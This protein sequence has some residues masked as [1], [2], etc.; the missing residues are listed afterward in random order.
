MFFW[1]RVYALSLY[2]NLNGF[3]W[4]FLWT[5]GGKRAGGFDDAGPDNKG[6]VNITGDGKF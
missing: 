6:R 5:G 3:K 4:V 1:Y 2:G